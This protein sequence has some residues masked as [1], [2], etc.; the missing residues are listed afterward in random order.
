MRGALL[1]PTG[2]QG[3]WRHRGRTPPRRR[4]SG[5]WGRLHL[6]RKV[7]RIAVCITSNSG[8][9]LQ[10]ITHSQKLQLG[11]LLRILVSRQPILII[12][13]TLADMLCKRH[14]HLFRLSVR[15]SLLP[16]GC[17][18][19]QAWSFEQQAVC[20]VHQ[21]VEDGVGECAIAII[22]RQRSTGSWLVTSVALRL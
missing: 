2:P 8:R 4:G 15:Q 9:N 12:P 20:G 18:I 11:H 6:S 5:P 3:L 22:S 21:A 7:R 10:A 16:A 13:A 17:W 14:F 1:T 19:A